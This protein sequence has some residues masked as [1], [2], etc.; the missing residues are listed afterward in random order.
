MKNH[1]ES[2]GLQ[3][4]ASQEAI[5][6]AFERLSKEL[7]P[8]NNENQ[9]FFIEEHEKVQEAYKVLYNSSILASEDG[10][11]GAPLKAK[12]INK[13][14]KEN[15]NTTKVNVNNPEKRYGKALVVGLS[16]ALIVS[17]VAVYII[18]T[19]NL[20]LHKEIIEQQTK[21]TR[22]QKQQQT[23]DSLLNRKSNLN[24][25]G[26]M[27]LLREGYI[28]ADYFNSASEKAAE[29]SDRKEMLRLNDILNKRKNNK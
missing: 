25:K 6:E 21:Y 20:F 23:I 3:E 2:L 16:I 13:P 1:Y 24:E 12:T 17:I 7:N 18:A 29:E 22:L 27:I 26:L 15:S 8:A 28:T 14:K 11:K 9:E 19:S 10:I 4:G 5:Q